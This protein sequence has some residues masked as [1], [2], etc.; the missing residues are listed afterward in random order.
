MSF[1]HLPAVVGTAFLVALVPALPAQAAVGCGAVLYKSTMLATDLHCPGTSIVIAGDGVVLDLGGHTISGDATS[2]GVVVAAVGARVQNG[3]VDGFDA[4]IRIHQEALV[5]LDENRP[6]SA[7]L[8][9]VTLRNNVIGVA[10]T[11]YAVHVANS[12]ILDNVT[13]LGGDNDDE[14]G[15]FNVTGSM[16]ARNREAISVSNSP[17]SRASVSQSVIEDNALGIS[18][19]QAVFAVSSSKIRRNGIGVLAGQCDGSSIRTSYLQGNRVGAHLQDAYEVGYQ[20]TDNYVLSN[21]EGVRLAGHAS[22]EIL[23]NRFLYNTTGISSAAQEVDIPLAY[24]GHITDNDFYRNGDGVFLDD[25]HGLA[26][27]DNR[28]WRN[29]GW[30]LYTTGGIDSAGNTAY[31]N[32]QPTQCFGVVCSAS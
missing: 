22:A 18:C 31:G 5:G 19:S 10:S 9:F 20:V 8:R 30:G 17:G 28:A 14:G 4:G 7:T 21:G 32:G 26:I 1:H 27:G 11:G 24:P 6:L 16:L 13:G 15:P 12:R 23:R 25:L 2:H 29:T 3:T